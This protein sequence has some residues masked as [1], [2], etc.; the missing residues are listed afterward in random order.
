MDASLGRGG[1]DHEDDGSAGQLAHAV[2]VSVVHVEHFVASRELRCM[3]C[4]VFVDF[5]K[6]LYLFT[7]GDLLLVS[8][9][10]PNLP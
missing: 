6:L 4:V 7:G 10:L 9:F 1:N 8:L 3:M 5:E 2:G